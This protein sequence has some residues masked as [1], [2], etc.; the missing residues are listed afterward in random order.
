MTRAMCSREPRFFSFF[1]QR[2]SASLAPRGYTAR[3]YPLGGDH[4]LALQCRV[5]ACSAFSSLFNGEIGA[6]RRREREEEITREEIALIGREEQALRCL[7]ANVTWTASETLVRKYVRD[8]RNVL[9]ADSF[10]GCNFLPGPVYA[11]K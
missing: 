9:R 3:R 10:P 11:R 6:D 4:D 2:F 5:R 7:S 8:K 1:T